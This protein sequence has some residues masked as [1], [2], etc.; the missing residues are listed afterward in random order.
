MKKLAA[1]VGL[2]AAF[3]A[4][5]F[6]SHTALY[7][8]PMPKCVP[9]IVALFWYQKPYQ[10]IFIAVGQAK[11]DR[12]DKKARSEACWLGRASAALAI[13]H[14]KVYAPMESVAIRNWFREHNPPITT[15]TVVYK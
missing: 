9:A 6:A 13:P 3:T 8:Q 2:L 14:R 1:V 15:G 7:S 11:P 5:A 12:D 10:P 4:P